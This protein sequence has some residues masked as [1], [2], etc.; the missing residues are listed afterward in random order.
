MFW[1]THFNIKNTWFSLSWEIIEFHTQILFVTW[2]TKLESTQWKNNFYISISQ[3]RAILTLH[4]NIDLKN[5]IAIFGLY[6]HYLYKFWLGEKCRMHSKWHSVYDPK[7]ILKSYQ[8]FSSHLN[9]I[10]LSFSQLFLGICILLFFYSIDSI[11]QISILWIWKSDIFHLSHFYVL[12]C[13]LKLFPAQ[14]ISKVVN[15]CISHDSFN[16][17]EQKKKLS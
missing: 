7:P 1:D 12:A 13:V 16:Y 2:L 10:F 15:F 8:F 4:A 11:S 9:S 3:L 17:L 5:L 14:S 6:P